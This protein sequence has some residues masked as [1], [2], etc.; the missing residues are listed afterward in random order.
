MDAAVTW[1]RLGELGTGYSG[2][3]LRETL[4]GNQPGFVERATM[5]LS[6]CCFGHSIP[7]F[8]LPLTSENDYPFFMKLF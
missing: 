4:S 2:T 7:S 6:P 5:A 1:Q 3:C 8:F